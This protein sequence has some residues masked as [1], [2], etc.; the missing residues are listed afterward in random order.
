[1]C[2]CART[3]YWILWTAQLIWGLRLYS[4][5]EFVRSNWIYL[6]I[7]R[8]TCPSDWLS[9]SPPFLTYRLPFLILSWSPL[10]GIGSDF[11]SKKPPLRSLL[12]GSGQGRVRWFAGEARGRS[13]VWWRHLMCPKPVRAFNANRRVR[14]LWDVF[15][16]TLGVPHFPK[17][18]KCT[19]IKPL[20]PS[21]NALNHFSCEVLSQIFSLAFLS[22]FHFFIL[23]F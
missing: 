12:P 10:H 21:L 17:I 18:D 9:A 14:I 20:L 7:S 5:R 3:S 13:L 4:C 1:M 11:T 19:R 15:R 2:T 16:R 22:P 6:N 8:P 23:S